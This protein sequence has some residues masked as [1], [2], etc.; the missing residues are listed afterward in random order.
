MMRL[1]DLTAYAEKKYNIKE[2]HSLPDYPEFSVL[3]DPTTEKWVA[4]LIRH[5]STELGEE[6]EL[7]DIKCGSEFLTHNKLPF[8]GAPFRMR[9]KNWIG[10]RFNEK[11]I[12]GVVFGLFDKAMT[13]FLQRNYSLI[14]YTSTF[15]AENNTA[16]GT[17]DYSKINNFKYTDTPIPVRPGFSDNT[18]NQIP[19]QIREM[20]KLYEFG[21]GSFA[22]KCRNFYVQGKFMEDYEDDAP[23]KGTIL[24]YFTTYRDLNVEQ[25][26]GY[27]TWRTKIR[28]GVFEPITTS[29]AYIYVYELLNGIGAKSTEDSIL[30]LLD[31]EKNY[32]D[33]GIGDPGMKRNIDKWIRELAV[34]GMADP[35]FTKQ[36]L[37]REMLL[38]DDAINVLRNPDNFGNEEIFNALCVF[39]GAKI[40]N[41]AVMKSNEPEAKN[42]FASVW[43]HSSSKY[44]KDGKSLFSLCF[45]RPRELNWHPL[46]NAIFWRKPPAEGTVYSVS[47]SRRYVYRNG[48]WKEYCFHSVS[49]DKAL[50][51]GL[52]Q[53][54]DRKLRLYLKAGRPLKEKPENAWASPLIDAV[55]ENDKKLK[56]EAARPKVTISF[57][58]LDKIRRDAQITRESLLTEEEKSEESIS[59]EKTGAEPQFSQSEVLSLPLDS[60]QV[61]I[62]SMLLRGESVRKLLKSTNQMPEIIAD[63][64]N[65]AL[66]DEIG[67]VSVECVGD[68]ILI[69]E[70]YRDD[71]NRILGG[72]I[73]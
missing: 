1:S 48:R 40:N 33:S 14:R 31:F 12:P 34:V 19:K 59:E 29:L 46:E 51:E 62:L 30:K 56:A 27:F 28:K 44:K 50:F 32:I 64:I 5:W 10:V 18:A 49:F 71:V 60:D 26:R 21:D 43:K 11:T 65:E 9:S 7:C 25:L 73:I 8:I 36:Y 24:R 57:E 61:Q 13:A 16:K 17:T 69:V 35:E 67:D 52:L 58:D 70:D 15:G 68:D 3:T 38:R 66:F 22:R 4:L 39:G 41:S 2:Q 37:S 55:I 20:V 54:T 53:E 45:G 47:S 72:N 63:S 42:L 23:W 6:I